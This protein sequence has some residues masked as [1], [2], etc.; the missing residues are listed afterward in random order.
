MKLDKDNL[1]SDVFAFNGVKNILIT[2]G[3]GVVTLERSVSGSEFY[4]LTTNLQGD[5]AVFDCDGGCA[6]NGTLSD[7]G[8]G[9]TYRFVAEMDEGE[10]DIVLSRG[11]SC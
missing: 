8:S 11:G 10:I 3:P 2:G 4:P 5:A 1:I 9:T 6:F 7:Q